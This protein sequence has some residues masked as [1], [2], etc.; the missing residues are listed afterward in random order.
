MSRC[1][2]CGDDLPCAAKIGIFQQLSTADQQKISDLARHKT[3]KRGELLYSP[4]NAPG[5]YLIA[6]GRVKVYS[7][8]ET[9]KETLLRVLSEGDFVGESV[10]FGGEETTFGE[11]LTDTQVCLIP[12]SEFLDLLLRYPTISIRLLEELNRRLQSLAG[13]ASVGCRES[14]QSRLA[15]YLLELSAAQESSS[16][17]IPLTCREL[18]RFLD[19]TPETLSRRLTALEQ[20][21]LL[22]KSG[23]KITLPDKAGL[24]RLREA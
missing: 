3:C 16:F 2:H 19:T 20:A 21:G 9:G 14:V 8:S 5:L 22:Q 1:C 4:E 17:T 18:A 6:R 10:L 11:A 7:V 15:G 13:R 24:E 23:R 12:K